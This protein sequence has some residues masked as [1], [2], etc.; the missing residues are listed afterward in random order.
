MIGLEDDKAEIRT[1]VDLR[2]KLARRGAGSN[3]AAA[4]ADIDLDQKVNLRSSLPRRIRQKR[5]GLGLIDAGADAGV[6]RQVRQARDVPR[7]DDSLVTTTSP[8]PLSTSGSASDT[9]GYYILFL[10]IPSRHDAVQF[11]PIVVHREVGRPAIIEALP[12]PPAAKTPFLRAQALLT[13]TSMDSKPVPDPGV[14]AGVFGLT[15]AEVR[16]A[17]I[18]ATG[19]NLDLAADQLHVSRETVRN[20]LKAVFAKTATHHQAELVALLSNLL[21]LP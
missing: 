5:D 7:A 17:S 13:F 8:M 18:L 6:T 16:L 15:P 1:A 14:L 2:G 21:N 12:I 11:S 20:Q 9:S 4:R 19:A 3:A 10:G